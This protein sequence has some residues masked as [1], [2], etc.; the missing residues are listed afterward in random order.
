MFTSKAYSLMVLIWLNHL[1][2]GHTLQ[3]ESNLLR[4]HALAVVDPP[5]PPFPFDYMKEPYTRQQSKD[6]T[7]DDVSRDTPALPLSSEWRTPS[8]GVC[9]PLINDYCKKEIQA[10]TSD[11]L[12]GKD[13][14]V[15]RGFQNAAMP[16]TEECGRM[17]CNPICLKGAIKCAVSVGGKKSRIGEQVSQSRYQSALCAQ[18]IAA[19]CTSSSSGGAGG[20]CSKD[21]MIARWVDDQMYD[22]GVRRNEDEFDESTMDRNPWDPTNRGY[23]GTW[24][25]IRNGESHVPDIMPLEKEEPKTQDGS[26]E[27][28]G[29]GSTSKKSGSKPVKGERYERHQS[30]QMA[31]QGV[32]GIVSEGEQLSGY[33]LGSPNGGLHETQVL[34]DP[35]SIVPLLPLPA[36]RYSGNWG[37]KAL[38]KQR[39]DA[40]QACMKEVKVKLEP[41]P[42][43]CAQLEAPLPDGRPRPFEKGDGEARLQKKRFKNTELADEPEEKFGGG[44]YGGVLRSDIAK[45]TSMTTELKHLA[46]DLAGHSS[47]YER[48]VRFVGKMRETG[49]LSDWEKSLASK[50][51]EVCACLGCCEAS[52]Q[53]DS[54]KGQCF[55]PFFQ[56]T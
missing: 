3:A 48:C 54:S 39:E 45:L 11:Q 26:N 34:N 44:G 8:S 37:G 25:N 24:R 19:V 29:D 12:D 46:T 9:G 27:N 16:L 30:D 5:A 17:F 43:F 1:Y 41:N 35:T 56:A 55:F 22:S 10:A 33:G 49:W 47:L 32:A 15:R 20:C 13:A 6:F 28:N 23:S 7:M 50:K 51:K 36:C 2:C 52:S 21:A 18:V 40:C 31:A 38:K 4:A 53:S 14:Y 42:N